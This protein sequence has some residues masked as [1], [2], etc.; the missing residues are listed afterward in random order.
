MYV[1]LSIAVLTLVTASQFSLGWPWVD[2]ITACAFTGTGRMRTLEMSIALMRRGGGEEDDG[3]D[4]RVR[5][6]VGDWVDLL[7]I[8]FLYTSANFSLGGER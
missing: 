6:M 1:Q 4:G 8:Y 3:G 2:V 7:L 5:R